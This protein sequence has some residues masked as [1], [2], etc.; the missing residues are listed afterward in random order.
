MNIQDFSSNIQ[1]INS[2]TF[3]PLFNGRH[4]ISLPN[5]GLPV[6]K[7]FSFK[8][9]K[10]IY[11][12]EIGD[13]YWLLDEGMHNSGNPIHIVVTGLTPALTQFIQD[14]L[15]MDIVLWHYDRE[16]NTYWCQVVS[17]E[18]S[19]IEELFYKEIEKKALLDE[20]IQEA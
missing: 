5:V 14:Y 8:E 16:K 6:F 9:M 11:N 15:F 18:N 1:D 10:G 13:T 17:K 12:S 4:E 19:S 3:Y 20:E 7:D 2:I